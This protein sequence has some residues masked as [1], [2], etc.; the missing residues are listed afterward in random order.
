M[1]HRNTA[2]V[3][4][5]TLVE[6]LVVIAI[7]AIL[8]GVL[9]PA[10][11]IA[12]SRAQNVKCE[13]NLHQLYIAS[14]LYAHDNK[15]LFPS[16]FQTGA[17]S[18]RRGAGVVDPNNTAA[19]PEGLGIPA[20]YNQLHYLSGNGVWQCPAE[21]DW[22]GQWGC[23][24]T[25][26]MWNGSF[27]HLKSYE[28]GLPNTRLVAFS[29]DQTVSPAANNS[30]TPLPTGTY[31]YGYGGTTSAADTSVPLGGR[32]NGSTWK[33]AYIYPHFF[34]G[35]KKT[36]TVGTQFTLL[37]GSQNAYFR[38]WSDGVVE[39]RTVFQDLAKD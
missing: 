25:N 39:G 15:D 12:R 22:Y 14:L 17:A 33:Y 16:Q 7:I 18:L 28:R 10:L 9:L 26:Y 35:L 3:Q 38:V 2:R 20:L 27:D 13:S 29:C 8:I 19:G 4:A 36:A 11:S 30:T 32:K 34:Q 24:Y 6:L 1:R 21:P 37:P 23:T 31:G 5:F